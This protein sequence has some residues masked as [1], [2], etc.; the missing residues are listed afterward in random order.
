M[1]V[2]IGGKSITKSPNYEDHLTPAKPSKPKMITQ[3]GKAYTELV[4]KQGSHHEAVVAVTEEHVGSM[5][6]AEDELG[7]V[8][9]KGGRTIN[10]GNFESARFDCGIT[11]PC[12][13]ETLEATYEFCTKWV[14]DK[15][16]QATQQSKNDE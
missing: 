7:S 3:N 15:I 13:K 16:V 14:S 1:A 11:L 4:K 6:Y 10:L 2:T 9:V 5:T 8:T 12:T